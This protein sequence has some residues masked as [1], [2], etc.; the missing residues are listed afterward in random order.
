MPRTRPQPH[1]LR[2]NA[3]Q[4]TYPG[5]MLFRTAFHR[6]YTTRFLLLK[7]ALRS[8]ELHKFFSLDERQRTDIKNVECVALDDR[9][10]QTLVDEIA[11]PDEH[12]RAAV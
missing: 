8:N 12:P 11:Q 6:G 7:A 3:A 10:R 4:F 1:V 5:G 2:I 9:N